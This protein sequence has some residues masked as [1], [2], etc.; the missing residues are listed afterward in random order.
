MMV[1]SFRTRAAISAGAAVVAA[2]ALAVAPTA[3]AQN[4]MRRD[5]HRSKRQLG[6]YVYK[7]PD[8]SSAA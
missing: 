8:E 7:Q 2:P 4:Q 1:S 3:H 6:P 5:H